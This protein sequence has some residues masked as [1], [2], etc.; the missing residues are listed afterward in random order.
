MYCAKCDKTIPDERLQEISLK[1]AEQFGNDSL[2]KGV[3]PVC[4]TRLMNPKRK[5]K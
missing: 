4:G 3:C 1:L 5:A 2:S